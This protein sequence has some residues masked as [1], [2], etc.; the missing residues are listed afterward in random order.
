MCS[1]AVLDGL[2]KLNLNKS[3]TQLLQLYFSL[4]EENIFNDLLDNDTLIEGD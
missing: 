1:V 4:T 3:C 2:E